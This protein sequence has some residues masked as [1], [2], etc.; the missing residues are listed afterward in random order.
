MILCHC[1]YQFY[2]KLGCRESTGKGFQVHTY[3]DPYCTERST[4]YNNYVDTS[5]LQ[6]SFD[7]CKR[8]EYQSYNKGYNGYNNGNYY[9]N[10]NNNNNNNIYQHSSPLCSAMYNYK[11]SCGYKCRKNS[12]KTNSGTSGPGFFSN[13]G[14]TDYDGYNVIEIVML[15]VLS[16]SGTP[17]DSLF[18]CIS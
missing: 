13:F 10:N 14:S 5:T 9:N 17:T 15:W 3:T 7:Y 8:C 11:E 4:V 12:K 18:D 6:V 16:I 2:Y 1:R